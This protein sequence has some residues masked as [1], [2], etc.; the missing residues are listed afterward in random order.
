M[1]F[2]A[3]TNQNKCSLTINNLQEVLAMNNFMVINQDGSEIPFSQ[4]NRSETSG[5]WNRILRSEQKPEGVGLNLA[6]N[7]LVYQ[8]R[9]AAHEKSSDKGHYRFYP[10][11]ALIFNLISDWLEANAINQYE[12]S[13]IMTPSMYD[14]EDPVTQAQA[15]IFDDF[16]YHV[17]LPDRPKDYALKFNG[18]LGAFKMMSSANLKESQLPARIHEMLRGFRYI[19]SGQLSGIGKGRTFSLL[20]MKSFCGT[21]QQAMEEYVLLHQK[22]NGLLKEVGHH[23]FSLFRTTPEFLKFTKEVA[24]QIASVDHSPV[25]VKVVPEQKQYWVMKHT[26]FTDHPERI[27]QIQLDMENGKRFGVCYESKEGVSTHGPI[28]H[29][30]LGSVERWMTLFARDA[31]ALHVPVLPL[32]LSPVQV[33]VIPVKERHNV[34]CHDVALSLRRCS[35]RADMEDRCGGLSDHVKEAET[36]WLPYTL[37]CGDSEI[38]GNY[39]TLRIRGGEQRRVSLESFVESVK[40]STLGKPFRQLP[41]ILTSK[42]LEF[43]ML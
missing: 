22:A 27:V 24:A 40:I 20:D 6:L 31:L 14:W 43:E 23:S 21:L 3:R 17:R 30:S 35:I 8:M 28:I 13:A 2:V 25:V 1:Y 39:L 9:W 5:I 4:F 42:Q 15:G 34:Y 41:N 29:N 33:R 38:Q 32:W 37:L 18:D 10:A 16:I 7:K 11:G 36:N 12:S 26:V 19:Q